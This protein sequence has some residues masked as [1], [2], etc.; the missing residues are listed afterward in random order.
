MR[1][2]EYRPD[3]VSAP[4]DTVVEIIAILGM[5]RKYVMERLGMSG[6]EFGE[7]VAGN[8]KID[9]KLAG[10]LERLF[11]IPYSFW[12]AREKAYRDSIV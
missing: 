8:R 3:V 7:F 5:D 2:N 9:R 12:L 10:K 6:K 11:V 1:E 4:G